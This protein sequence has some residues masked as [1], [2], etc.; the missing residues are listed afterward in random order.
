MIWLLICTKQCLVAQEANHEIGSKV[1]AF[2]K[3]IASRSLVN[4]NYPDNALSVQ[5]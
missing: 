5:S 3:C 1:Q 2:K 4:R